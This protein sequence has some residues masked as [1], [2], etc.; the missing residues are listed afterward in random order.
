MKNC[1]TDIPT[2]EKQEI[3]SKFSQKMLNSGHSLASTQFILVH[4]IVKYNVLLKNSKLPTDHK[5]Y[6]PFHCSK[7]FDVCNRKLR[8]ILAITS[9]YDKLELN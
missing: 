5:D 7:D 6:Q 8:K 1:H 4:G 9:W 3:L 2:N